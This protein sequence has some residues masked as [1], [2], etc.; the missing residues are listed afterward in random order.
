[1][2]RLSMGSGPSYWLPICSQQEHIIIDRARLLGELWENMWRLA[3][4]PNDT[5]INQHPRKVVPVL[6]IRNVAKNC[7]MKDDDRRIGRR[8]RD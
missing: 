4:E 2:H 8:L 7:G 3:A 6:L 5:S 1:M